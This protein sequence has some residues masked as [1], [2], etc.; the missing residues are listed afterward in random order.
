MINCAAY[1]AVDKAETPDG[2]IAAW[3]ANAQGP[4]LLSRV[5]AENG[6]ALVHISSDYVFDGGRKL[7]NESEPASPLSVYG[8][9]KAA[10]DI[11]VQGCPKHYILRTSWVIGDG[12]NFVKTMAA[13]SDRVANPH[14]DLQQVTVVNDQYGRLTFTQDIAAAILHLLKAKAPYGT[15][16]CTGSGA[17]KTWADIAATVFRL[18]NGNAE[19]VIPASSAAYYEAAAGPVA[20]RPTHSTLDLT[21]LKS[22]GFAIPDW[23]QE[24]QSYLQELNN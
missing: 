19:K 5:C 1:T 20:P 15:Y 24:L 6:I 23:E 18:R 11:A 16:D 2:R 12:N 22:T 7:H 8:Q 13:L 10:G 21:K 9:S 17:T 4:A 14:D 3:K